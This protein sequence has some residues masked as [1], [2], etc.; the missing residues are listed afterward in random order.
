MSDNQS[1]NLILFSWKPVI[2]DYKCDTDG[3]HILGVDIFLEKDMFSGMLELRDQ[4][5]T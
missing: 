5:E 3:V 1:L 4:W 2:F